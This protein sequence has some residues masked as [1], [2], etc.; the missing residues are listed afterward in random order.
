MK[1]Q[2]AE[3]LRGRLFIAGGTVRFELCRIDS[4]LG[5]QLLCLELEFVVGRR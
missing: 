3:N 2:E 4:D 5:S 1:A